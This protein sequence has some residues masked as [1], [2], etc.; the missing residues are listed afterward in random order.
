MYSRIQGQKSVQCF[1]GIAKAKAGKDSKV[2]TFLTF[3][4]DFLYINII[5]QKSN[6]T[7]KLTSA[8]Q[9]SFSKPCVS[10]FPEK[11]VP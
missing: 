1:R 2:I 11:Y 4:D 7:V 5:L 8:G 9:S 6:A 10:N 3:N